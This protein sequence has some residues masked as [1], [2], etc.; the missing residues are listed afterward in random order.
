MI[1]IRV[2]RDTLPAG[3]YMALFALLP[4]SPDCAFGG[5]NI[6]LPAEPLMFAIGIFLF[7]YVAR[8][9]AALRSAFSESGGSL[10]VISALWLGWLGFCAFFSSMPL[11]SWKFWVVEAGHWW[12]FAVGLTLF[13]QYRAAA[14]RLFLVSMVGV[15]VYTLLHHASYD[16]RA[17]QALLAPM[18]F[19]PENT[20]YGAVCGMAAAL[21]YPFSGDVFQKIP[22]LRRHP[23]RWRHVMFALLLAGVFFSFSRAAVL[24]LVV[25]GAV[26][27]AMTGR[28]WFRI[29]AA[30]ALL[31]LVA[32]TGMRDAFAD[33]LKRDVSSLERLNR[34]ACALRMGLDRPLNGFGPGTFQFQYIPYQKPEEMTRI[35]AVAPVVHRG[36]DTYG[37]GGGAHSE[38]AQALAETGWP[39]LLWWMM[40]V[41]AGLAGS[42]RHL[43]QSRG[44]TAQALAAGIFLCLLVF[45]LHSQV[46]NILHDGR[47]AALFWLCMTAL[48]TKKQPR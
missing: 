12:V 32:L 29:V 5:W 43:W 18:P 22:V 47:V 44:T 46:N 25:A 3:L 42:A 45:F 16:F 27:S 48:P 38:W 24:A 17:D 31:V 2:S 36:P 39:G 28:G 7:F 6:D 34:Y 19:F 11:V 41:L 33:R 40:L 30:G 37:R 14:L 10:L 15:V 26:A 23:E 13:P 4:W 21:W 35:S 9:P 8:N 20:L 1:S